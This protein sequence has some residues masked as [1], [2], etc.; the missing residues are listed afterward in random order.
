MKRVEKIIKEAHVLFSQIYHPILG[1]NSF[2]LFKI[3]LIHLEML[4]ELGIYV[5][6]NFW[7]RSSLMLPVLLRNNARITK[8]FLIFEAYM[9]LLH[10]R[11]DWANV[12][13]RCILIHIWID[14]F[15]MKPF[16]LFIFWL[17][18]IINKFCRI[19]FK[20]STMFIFWFD[21]WCLGISLW[22]SRWFCVYIILAVFIW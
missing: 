7:K 2:D 3:S 13:F 14:H 10:S 22:K 1:I 9:V 20:V 18:L 15:T 16:N 5:Q 11:M 19:K 21:W 6:S 17:I 12:K 8:M 4:W